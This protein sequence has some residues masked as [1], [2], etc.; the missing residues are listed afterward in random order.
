MAQLEADPVNVPT[1]GVQVRV[2]LHRTDYVGEVVA[3][4]R[5]RATV[6]YTDRYG[7]QRTVKVPLAQV[8]ANA[9]GA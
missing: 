9:A 6:R 3:L 2:C 1:I 8:Y 4:S 7:D 5:S